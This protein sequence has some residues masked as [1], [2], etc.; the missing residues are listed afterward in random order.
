MTEFTKEA[1]AVLNVF[2]EVL[3]K[4]LWHY[5]RDD[6]QYMIRLKVIGNDLPMQLIIR[7]DAVQGTV[8]LCS[9][10]PVVISCEKILEAAMIVNAYNDGRAFG[11]LELNPANGIIIF[12]LST[13]IAKA[14]LN[15]ETCI[16]II[17]FALK[18]IDTYNDKFILLNVGRL[19]ME[20]ILADMD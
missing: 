14:M 13:N 2:A 1:Q 8:M 12:R 16:R 19:S 20:E 15:A 7:A 4:R 6:A 9:Q 11:S 5:E 3:D 18:Q 17:D 10:M